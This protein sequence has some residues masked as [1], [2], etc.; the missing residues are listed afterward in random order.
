MSIKSE[1]KA[2]L[3]KDEVDRVFESLLSFLPDN[4]DE[5]G[6]VVIQSSRW[7]ELKSDRRT[8]QA[9]DKEIRREKNNLIA[10]LL[11]FINELPDEVSYKEEENEELVKPKEKGI[12][13]TRFKW[14]VFIGIVVVK[15]IVFILLTETGGFLSV[16]KSSIQGILWPVF[17]TSLI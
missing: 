9:E 13:E 8:E 1:L 14:I 17:A 16:Q 7:E 12:T 6:E 5:F 10:D 3:I 2:L 11:S 15:G 4:S